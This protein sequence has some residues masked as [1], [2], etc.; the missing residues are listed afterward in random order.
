MIVRPRSLARFC[1]YLALLTLASLP[2]RAEDSKGGPRDDAKDASS[3]AGSAETVDVNSI[4]PERFAA[5][6]TRLSPGEEIDIDGHLEEGAWQRAVA[7]GNFIQ[8]EPDLGRPASQRTEFK[9]LYDD[10]HIYFGVW[11]YDDEPQ[12]ILASEM[13]RD[14]GLRKGDQIKIS[15]DTFH[16][17]RNAF[18]F[19]T[20]PLGALK[21]ANTTEN[22]RV[23]NYDWNAV[24]RNKTSRD[25]KGWYVEI[26]VPL[27]QLRFKG[28]PGETLWGLNVC[29]VLLRRN[30]DSYW[31]PFPREWTPSGFS[32]MSG[33][34][35]ILGINGLTPRRRMEFV[36][37]VTPALSRNDLANT[38]KKSSGYGFDA[39]L[40]VTGSL[41]ADLTYKTDFA[42]VEADQEIVNLSRFSVFF[43]E[44]RQF[45]T[46][47][48][49]IFDFGRTGVGFSG[50]DGGGFGD[51][52][53]G[54]LPVFYSRRI[55]L[56]AGEQVPIV[57]GGKVTGRAGP[58]TIGLLNMQTDDSTS[59]DG[60]L[61]L[62]G[63]YGALRIKRNVL[64]QSTLGAIFL[65]RNGGPGAAFN[66][67]AGLDL[68]LTLG[69][70]LAIAS[71]V[72]KTFSPQPTSS[73]GVPAAGGN[74]VAAATDLGWKNDKW[75]F[76]AT[77]LDIAKDFNAE[78]GFIRRTDVRNLKVD[79]SATWR[80][81]IKGVRSLQASAN[82]DHFE[83][84]DGVMD[85]R[86]YDA[87]FNW[88]RPDSSS[89]RFS[90]SRDFDRLSSAFTTFAGD[91]APGGYWWNTYRLNYF[92][93]N[94]G[95]KLGGFMSGE[96]GGYYNGRKQAIRTGLNYVPNGTLLFEANY[97][98]NQIQLPGR[99]GAASNVFGTRLSYS[100]SP[101]LFVK[102]Y[103]QMNDER[104][105][106][107]L[108]F[109]LWYI[110]RPGSDIYVVYNQGWDQD[111]PGERF[112]R[113][114]DKSLIVKMTWWWSR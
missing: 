104:K 106:A 85:S 29:R 78:M 72:A 98:R 81:R 18:Y 22:G 25:D 14:S 92:G 5:I 34:G 46:E 84:H 95:R 57:G 65:N 112:L 113:S 16:D 105:L 27:S 108:N 70:N 62:G 86:G 23:I 68:G 97:S 6:A 53:A 3:S 73:N 99:P 110:Y 36:P 69:R 88:Q 94:T 52:G 107:S 2:A 96:M 76:G 111:L 87:S 58:Y 51:N 15:I 82:V 48:A 13:K 7:S 17:K 33:A 35:K 100:F 89:I 66:R 93:G 67:T 102:A 79:G 10:R 21:D 109:L 8:R 75:N 38:S 9:I 114:R 60:K 101:D 19:S 45:F 43:P 30:E 55:G 39:R 80:P 24:W 49:G 31:V 61:R 41:T 11:A 56:N 59:S 1:A 71:M 20:N 91:I 50:G 83:N 37:F 26:A 77:Y 4:D 40:G 12:R 47:S 74:G 63:N 44:K 103:A 42:Q 28:G 90:M 54:L 64:K 32:R